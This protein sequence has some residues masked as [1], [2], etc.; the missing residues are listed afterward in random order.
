MPEEQRH[1]PKKPLVT[2]EFQTE[3]DVSTGR[4]ERRMFVKMYF[5]ARDSGLLAAMPD[6]LWK[7]LCCLATYIDENGNCYPSQA[8]LARHLGVR[9]EAVNTRIQRLL[10]FRFKGEA[11]VSVSRP[12]ATQGRYAK[13][14]Y[15]VH[16]IASFAIFDEGKGAQKA[17]KCTMCGQPHME[18]ETMCGSANMAAANMVGAHTNKTQE[19]NQTHTG[20][21]VSQKEKRTPHLELVAYFHRKANHPE[22]V[23]P[24]PKE[25]GQAKAILA[26]HPEK[27]ARFIVDFALEK[28]RETHFRMRHFGAVLAY[29][30]EAI[31]QE[32]RAEAQRREAEENRRRRELEDLA[33][34]NSGP[35]LH[36][37]LTLKVGRF[38]LDMGRDP[39]TEEL[40]VLRREL[41][42]QRA[43]A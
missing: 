36:G 25:L 1:G 3:V 20:V 28:A 43:E 17:E 30:S 4:A 35:N 15:K 34:K 33:F 41:L 9:R 18:G 19:S 13:N 11:V 42:E 16:P 14:H 2:V 29:V 39:T 6:E 40:E 8:E 10:D 26:G 38:K 12:R 24:T 5:A 7:T 23:T 32:A 27:T 21:G 31:A 22:S 37:L